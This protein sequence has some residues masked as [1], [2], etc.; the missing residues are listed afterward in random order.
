ME[1]KNVF[2]AE[3]LTFIEFK[4][5]K[6]QVNTP[7]NFLLEKV[8]GYEVEHSLQLAFNLNEKL[9]KVDYILELKT[10]SKGDNPV[11]ASGIFHL[12]YIYRV[13]NLN[14]L[15]E[16]VENNLVKFNPDLGNALSAISYS[17]SRGILMTRMQGTALQNFILPIINP[18]KLLPIKKGE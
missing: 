11:E 10:K 14:E 16:V 15:T 12:V 2:T 17:T 5:L 4:F 18:D 6:D 7:E 3:K 13:E 1:S 9:S 8:D